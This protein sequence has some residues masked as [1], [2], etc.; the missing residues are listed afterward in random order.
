M[1]GGLSRSGM[2]NSNEAGRPSKSANGEHTVVHQIFE[3]MVESQPSSTALIEGGLCL[4][5]RELDNRA[6]QW[7]QELRRRGVASGDYVPL[8]MRRSACMVIAQIAV[9]K[10][11]AAYVPIDPETPWKRQE[12]MIGDCSARVVMRRD[13]RSEEVDIQS[14]SSERT[15]HA[16]NDTTGSSA[17]Y[18][19]Y[20]SGSTG[21]PKGVVVP[22]SAIVGL[23]RDTN[24]ISVNRSD[25]VIHGSNPA[26]DAS[27]F[28][29]WVALLNG[30]RLCIV[31]AEVMLDPRLLAREIGKNACT[32]AFLTTALFNRY[33]RIMPEVFRGLRYVLAGGEEADPTAFERVLKHGRPDNLLNVYGPTET[34]TFA[35]YFALSSVGDTAT[36]LPIGRPVSGASV[37]V[38]DEFGREVAS[39]ADGEICIGGNGLARGY[40]RRPDLTALRFVPAPSGAAAGGRMYRT[41]D[42]GRWLADGN[43]EFLGRVDSQVKIRGFRIELAEIEATLLRHPAVAEAVV[44]TR[45]QQSGDKQII[46]FVVPRRTGESTDGT[47]SGPVLSRIKDFLAELLPA[48]MLPDL[49]EVETL[50]LTANGK[51]DRKKLVASQN[52]HVGSS[53]AGEAMGGSVE[54]VLS[55]IWR[56]A[57]GVNDFAMTDHFAQL[58]E[59]RSMH[60][61]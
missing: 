6:S 45:E 41:G 24:Y 32:I 26:F 22:H 20:T 59:A 15:D 30:A 51:I 52:N 17:A 37:Y 12:N 29:V 5:Y 11:G 19:M 7:A 50:P 33:A 10:A 43:L 31:G 3:S 57:L 54:A 23:V 28:E 1:G 61:T 60:W 18:V 47:V 34:T 55:R 8:I 38:L 2:R 21:S 48:Y 46:G 36:R 44:L 35:S 40:L 27:T 56:D 39:G 49:T 42:R 14:T 13:S 9:L 25:S 16:A 4:T 58:G 53:E